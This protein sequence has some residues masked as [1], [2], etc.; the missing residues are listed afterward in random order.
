MLRTFALAL[1]SV[2]VLSVGLVMAAEKKETGKIKKIDADKNTITVTIKDKDQTFDIG[3]DV[4]FVDAKGE[5]LKTFLT[6]Q[7]FRIVRKPFRM[8]DLREQVQELLDAA[9]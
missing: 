7:F 6:T 1:A 5:N 2:L 9:S 8:D 4:K 3:K